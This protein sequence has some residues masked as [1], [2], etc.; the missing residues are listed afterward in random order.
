MQ[1]HYRGNNLLET[2]VIV[3]I[4]IILAI[5]AIPSISDIL[6]RK[7]MATAQK[8]VVDTLRL[9]KHTARTQNTEIKV[10]ISKQAIVITARKNTEIQHVNLPKR[11]TIDRTH[12]LIFLPDGRIISQKN[13]DFVDLA[14]LI[15]TIKSSSDYPQAL[16]E[17]VSINSLGSIASM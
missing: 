16:I 6:L 17:Q 15:I 4:V 12:K 2:V 13:A 10:L 9:A 7:D 1:N 11:V 8:T 3:S 5:I 14:D